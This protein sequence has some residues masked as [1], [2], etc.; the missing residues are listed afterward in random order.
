MAQLTLDQR[1]LCDIQGRLFELALKNGYDCPTFIRAF[2]NSRTAA[3]LD[4][5]YDRLQ[6]AGEEYILEELNDEVGGLKKAGERYSA[7]VMYWAGY[8]YRYWH[9]YTG[10]TSKVI[11]EA[12]NAETMNDCWLGFHT[13]DVEM[14]IDDLKELH[15]QK[16][17]SCG[18]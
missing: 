7:E 12:A 11:F 18:Q 9:Y 17:R 4:D 8:T 6:W 2:M 13:F 3:A 10:E 1:Q 14:A 15:T 5:T 16:S